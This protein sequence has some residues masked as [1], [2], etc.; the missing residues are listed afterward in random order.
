[1]SLH[2][3][4]HFAEK[5]GIGKKLI[6]TVRTV[7]LQE[8]VDNGAAWRR[9]SGSDPPPMSILDDS[10]PTRAY[11]CH[12]APHRCGDQEACQVTGRTCAGSQNHRALR[13]N[14]KSAC[15]A[16]SLLLSTCWASATQITA[17]ITKFG[18][19]SFTSMLCWLTVCHG[20]TDLDD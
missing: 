1:M 18:F 16:L 12:P 15:T 4:N 13:E 8:H 6:L 14:G 3:N 20:M 2:I 19:T 10:V 11:W 7:I 5:R 17:A 9:Q